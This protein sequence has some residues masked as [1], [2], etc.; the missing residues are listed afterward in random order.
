MWSAKPH[1]RPAAGWVC[2]EL[3]EIVQGSR[4]PPGS[5]QAVG[6]QVAPSPAA[7]LPAAAGL[8]APAATRVAVSKSPKRG[9][10]PAAG[11]HPSKKKNLA[12]DLR[13]STMGRKA[14]AAGAMREATVRDLSASPHSRHGGAGA[15]Q[16]IGE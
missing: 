7:E 8:A 1:T 3:A 11:T 13:S 2:S 9:T 4:T 6:A 16:R 14:K 10:G 12:F 5:A 15:L